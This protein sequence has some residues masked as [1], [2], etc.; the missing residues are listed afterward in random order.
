MDPQT[1]QGEQIPRSHFISYLDLKILG[2]S[3]LGIYCFL[4][5]FSFVLITLHFQEKSDGF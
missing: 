3:T 1:S 5:F 2:V 4:D